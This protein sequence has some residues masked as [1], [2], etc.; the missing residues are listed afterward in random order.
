MVC[1]TSRRTSPAPVRAAA[2]E[3]DAGPVE[4]LDPGCLGR[5]AA[6]E[7]LVVAGAVGLLGG[8]VDLVQEAGA[9]AFQGKGDAVDR[10]G[11]HADALHE[12]HSG[13]PCG[14]TRRPAPP[15]LPHP[16]LRRE[17][18]LTGGKPPPPLT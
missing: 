16:R 2:G 12:R 11:V 7:A 9:G 17:L 3:A 5:P 13:K 6:G 10:D 8:G 1:A 14:P 4:A 18:P 15:A